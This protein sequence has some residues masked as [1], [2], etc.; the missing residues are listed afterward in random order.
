MNP[1][2]AVHV[3]LSEN[4]PPTWGGVARVAYN[5]SHAL[6]EDGYETLLC[7]F[8]RY[9]SDPLYRDE[10]FRV[11]PISSTA[12]RQ[13]KDWVMAGLLWRIRNTHRGRPVILYA[14]TWKLARVARFVAPRLGWTLLV[15]A[16]G[17]EVT[18]QRTRGKRRAMLGVFRDA[19]LC[20][21]VSRYTAD[22]LVQAGVSRDRVRV[23][24]NGVDTRMFHP[25]TDAADLE[26]VRAL[27]HRLG[28]E[29]AIMVLT[30]A[31]V[32]ERK[33]QDSVI[34]ALARLRDRRTQDAL[35]LRYVIAG[36]GPEAE[37]RRLK[38]LAQRLGVDEQVVFWG[39]VEPA[40][41]RVF[42][43][44]CDIYVMNSRIVGP[45]QDVEGFGITFLEA[46]ACGK[47]VIGGRSGGVVDAVK[48]GR[49]G[50]LVDP[51]DPEAL[52]NRLESLASDPALRARMGAE[53]LRRAREEFGIAAAR[54]SLLEMVRELPD[55]PGRGG[56]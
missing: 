21:G 16:H 12:W 52:A 6:G 15:F 29:H 35:P 43:N 33:G 13:R 39:Y 18:R 25:L 38:D 28:C 42:Y 2:N 27:R 30:L 17:L 40:Q 7:G 56:S 26:R 41:M 49:S 50:F 24:N 19:D 46:G 23:L 55:P 20:L 47:P 9:V 48:D 5:L 11:L 45:D 22:L 54:D 51:E 14:L 37:V 31:R 3:V 8:D 34:R 10:P 36:R 4:V 44:A 53:G 32:I 1:R